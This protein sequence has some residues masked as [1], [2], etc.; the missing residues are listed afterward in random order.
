MDKTITNSGYTNIVIFGSQGS[1]KDIVIKS[2]GATRVLE[3]SGMLSMYHHKMERKHTKIHNL[4]IYDIITN[5]ISIVNDIFMIKELINYIVIFVNLDKAHRTSS[6]EQLQRWSKVIKNYG[7]FRQCKIS[8]IGIGTK[9]SVS[10]DTATKT[11]K[12][13]KINK[14]GFVEIDPTN[15]KDI[16]KLFHAKI[17]RSLAGP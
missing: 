13:C 3:Q 8:V 10:R 9:E 7:M 16:I 1:G 11:V 15:H 5:D 2:L 12:W 14:V 4:A 6:V 17:P